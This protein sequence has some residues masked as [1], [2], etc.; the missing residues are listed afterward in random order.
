MAVAIENVQLRDS[1]Q[2]RVAELQERE[3]ALRESEEQ[4]RALFTQMQQ[5]VSVYE[6]VQDDTGAVVDH[7]LVARNDSFGQ[8]F[9]LDQDSDIGKS[10]RELNPQVTEEWIQKAGGV[11]LTGGSFTLEY[12]SPRAQRHLQVMIFSPRKGQYAGIYT[13]FTDLKRAEE[14]LR[15]ANAD[16]AALNR[17]SIE[18][19]ECRTYQSLLETISQ[20]LAEYCRAV[21]VVL[22]DFDR[23]RRVLAPKYFH[24]DGNLLSRAVRLVGDWITK[25]E[26]IIGDEDYERIMSSPVSKIGTLS[27]FTFGTIPESVG[28]VIQKVAGIEAFLAMNLVGEGSLQGGALIGLSSVGAV[29]TDAFLTS[30]AHIASASI[31]RMKAEEKVRYMSFHDQLT[32]LYNRHFLE[33]EM[34]RM[35]TERQLP[36]SVIMADVDGLKLVNDTYG[37]LRGDEMLQ[38]AASCIKSCCRAE[39]IVSRWGGDEY[40]I[41]LPQTSKRQA[42]ALCKRITAVCSSLYVEDVPVAV[43]LGFATKTSTKED[44]AKVLDAAEDNMYKNKLAESRSTKSAVVGALLQA[45]AEK[46]HETEAHTRRMQEV[47]V[48]MG[49]RAGL[50]D[51]ELS[52]LKL[53][54]TLHDIGKI[55]IPEE[56]LTRQGPLSSEEWETMRTHPHV[57]YRIAKA[58]EHFAHVA[59]E[60]LAHHERWD[61]SGYPQGLYRTEIPMLARIAAIADA[62]EVMSHGR[63]YKPAM[64]RDDIIVEMKKCAG[65]QFDPELVKLFLADF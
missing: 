45:L 15:E 61:G 20:Q 53:L 16:L 55:N 56:L 17:Y 27:Q 33:E 47:A 52:R 43:S 42:E 7:I 40:V 41:L 26:P 36:L 24:V 46:S 10:I 9:G 25:V 5:P 19:S 60:I 44:L 2:Q 34:A 35:D 14:S 8:L 50:M 48:R 13:D 22:S 1:L 28:A 23:E 4:Y 39:D 30:F 21:A 59:D 38:A 65:T 58:T 18:Q 62:Y 54:I 32:G 57:G 12:T 3:V 31:A 6:I 37:H 29:P 64:S 51:S 11:A 49:E 63:P